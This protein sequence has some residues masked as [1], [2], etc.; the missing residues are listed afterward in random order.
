MIN[1]IKHTQI[2]TIKYKNSQC[3]N[4]NN[5]VYYMFIFIRFIKIDDMMIFTTVETFG[6]LFSTIVRV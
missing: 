6:D 4:N 2:T 3:N 1:R 5:N